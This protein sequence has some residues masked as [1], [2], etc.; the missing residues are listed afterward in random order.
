[1]SIK[2][3]VGS[4]L[5]RKGGLLHIY[6]DGTGGKGRVGGGPGHGGRFCD[7]MLDSL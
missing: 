6:F 1:M 5:R 3:L 2:G 7:A 4:K